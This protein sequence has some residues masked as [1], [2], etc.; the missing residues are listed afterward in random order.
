M[1]MY[2][3]D[4]AVKMTVFL[5]PVLKSCNC[6]DTSLNTFPVITAITRLSGLFS[7]LFS[8]GSNFHS[9]IEKYLGGMPE[10][11]LD[12]S[13]ANEGYWSSIQTVFPDIGEVVN[14]EQ[15]VQHPQLHYKGIYDC[16]AKYR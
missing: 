16:V 9:C 4:P 1:S 5:I 12:L 13:G 15:M 8:N 3:P 10:E 14:T 2:V 11:E 7:E 6:D